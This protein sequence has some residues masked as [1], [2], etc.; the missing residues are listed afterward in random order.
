MSKRIVLIVFRLFFSL[1]TLAAIGTQLVI[2]ARS[3]GSIVNFFSYFTILSNLFASVVML[4]GAW[5]LAVRRQPSASDDILRGVSVVCMA[6]VGIVFSLLLRDV[7]L[8]EL[9]PWINTVTHYIMPVAVV[10]DWLYQPPLSKLAASGIV[11]WMIFPLIYLVYSV[12]RG[13]I[14]NWYAYPFF[15]PALSGGYGGVAL[16]CLAIAVTFLV[17]SWL[18]LQLGNRLQRNVP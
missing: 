5:S 4:L 14:V 15:N 17:L 6:L 1:L 9:R 16:Y 18:L 12:V 11:K 2:Q 3:G 10:L 13:A 7:D 8:G